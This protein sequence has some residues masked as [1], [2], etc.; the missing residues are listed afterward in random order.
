[1]TSTTLGR[2]EKIDL[3]DIWATEAQD[4]T[5]WLASEEN[6]AVLA[7]AINIDLEFEAQEKNVGPFR[8]DILCRNTDDGSWVLIEN[9]LERT[10]HSHLGQLMTYAAGLHAV[11]IVWIAAE[12]NEQHRASLDWLNEITDESFRFFGLEVELWR[13]DGSAA[14]PKF[15]VVSKPN[16]WSRQIS[17]AAKRISAGDL[18][19][20][21]IQQ[22]KYWT[23]FAESLR[24]A[25]SPVTP[26]KPPPQHWYNFGIGRT[27]FKLVTTVNSSRNRIGAEM[28]MGANEAKSYFH[29]LH[30][31]RGEIETVIGYALDWQELPDKKGSRVAIY[32]EDVEPTD[33][34]KWPEQHAWLRDKLEMLDSQFR[35][36]I[37]A[38][39]AE[40]WSD[41][42]DDAGAAAE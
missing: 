38:L 11:T 39:N 28:F 4:F 6:L 1:M 25:N 16:N 12:F 26:Q 41:E 15:N 22:L 17:Q 36:R 3:R 42:K 31:D 35:N 8:A 7:N 13:I 24:N 34:T 14:A 27:D 23:V 10:D 21:K 40:D 30:K 9:Q 19:D 33:E 29:L 32:L 5:P 37:R 2:L 20:T 18:S